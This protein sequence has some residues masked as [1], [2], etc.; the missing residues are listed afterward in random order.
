MGARTRK[1]AAVAIILSKS[2]PK[3]WKY[4][5][6]KLFL[7]YCEIEVFFLNDRVTE[8]WQAVTINKKKAEMKKKNSSWHMLNG[9]NTKMNIWKIDAHVKIE[10][11]W[12]E[13]SEKRLSKAKLKARSKASRRDI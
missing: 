5:E 2:R 9:I 10:K 4:V 1:K 12:P 6:S 8:K 11:F 7:T 13:L 3:K